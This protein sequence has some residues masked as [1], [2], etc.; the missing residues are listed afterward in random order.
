MVVARNEVC[1]DQRSYRKYVFQNIFWQLSTGGT[2]VVHLYCCFSFEIMMQITGFLCWPWIESQPWK[3]LEFQKKK[4]KKSLNC[5]AEAEDGN[6][7]AFMCLFLYVCLQDNSESCQWILMKFFGGVR[8]VT[9]N[10]WT[11]DYTLV[12]IEIMMQI[13]GFMC[14]PWIESQPW[15][16]LEFHQKQTEKVLELFWKKSLK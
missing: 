13:T 1:A 4:L 10:S 9:Y 3:V 11:A 8:Y 7:F 14:W 15:K 2:V 5:F 16:V 6:V 12:V